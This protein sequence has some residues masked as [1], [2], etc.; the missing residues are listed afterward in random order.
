[1][2]EFD[3]DFPRISDKRL[4]QFVI[5]VFASYGMRQWDAKISAERPRS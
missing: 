5:D 2:V 4:K 3:T 1:M